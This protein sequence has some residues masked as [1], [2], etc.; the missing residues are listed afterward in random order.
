MAGQPLAGKTVAVTR[1]ADQAGPLV[2]R[3][4]NMGAVVFEV[5]LI[6]IADP[7]D[8]GAALRRAVARQGDYAWV[9]LTSPNAARRYLDAVAA[10]SPV[11]SVP[12]PKVACVGPGTAQV[13]TERGCV[14]DLVPK[15]VIGEGLVE[16]FP[17][18]AAKVLFPRA[19]VA[20]AVVADGLRAKGWEVDVVDAYRTV[21]AKVTAQHVQQLLSADMVVLTS[22]STATATASA[23]AG[24]SPR[25]IVSMGIATTLTAANLGLTVTETADPS[26]ID[27][28][29]AA[30]IRVSRG[31]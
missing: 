28:L 14:V 26:T 19:E 1:A 18:G 13:V 25:R 11:S 22:S 6:E 7:I 8:G 24:A 15:R 23:L 5:P 31:S 27:G 20:R 12:A 3:L 21:P 2:T 16:A 9:V 4:Q 17:F 29:L 30:C 10:F